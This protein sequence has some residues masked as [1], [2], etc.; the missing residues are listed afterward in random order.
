MMRPVNSSPSPRP[1]GREGIK[2][3]WVATM[4]PEALLTGLDSGPYGC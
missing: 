4:T 1:V 3:T 2:S